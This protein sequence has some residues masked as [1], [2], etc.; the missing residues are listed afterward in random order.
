MLRRYD[1]IFMPPLIFSPLFDDFLRFS[2]A[3]D[4]SP[5]AFASSFSML[6][7]YYAAAFMISDTARAMITPRR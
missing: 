7:R 4:A 3:A 5:V 6:L 1:I 2:I